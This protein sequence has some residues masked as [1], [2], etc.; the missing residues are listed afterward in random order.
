MSDLDGGSWIERFTAPDH[1]LAPLGHELVQAHT[2][3]APGE[4]LEKGV[5]R[6]ESV[7]DGALPGWREREVWRRR[8]EIKDLMGAV[9]LP[10]ATWR[11][12][13]AIDR[14]DGV[15][16][17]GDKV[18]A[19]GLLSEVAFASASRAAAGEPPLA[20]WRDDEQAV[21]PPAGSP[22]SS[23]PRL[24]SVMKHWCMPNRKPYPSDV[25]DE[26]I[27]NC[28]GRTKPTHGVCGDV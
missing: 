18:A 28:G 14:G 25:S 13:P 7:L 22:I 9:D 1:S 8:M 3:L 19:P 27:E 6:L 20:R 5:R 17:A 15:F 21:S 11:D 2:G 10:G 4:P 26:G 24:Q 16:L 23:A 12:R